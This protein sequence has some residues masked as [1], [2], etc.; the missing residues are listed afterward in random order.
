MWPIQTEIT[1][2]NSI[3]KVVEISVDI[4]SKPKV[5]SDIG[6]IGNNNLNQILARFNDRKDL[7]VELHD[8]YKIL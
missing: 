6:L 4:R 7:R 2:D 3:F 5:I 8:F 1:P